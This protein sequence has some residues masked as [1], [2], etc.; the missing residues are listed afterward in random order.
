G[1]RRG[2]GALVRWSVFGVAWVIVKLWRGLTAVVGPVMRKA[3]DLAMKPYAGAE[4]GYLKLLPSA[5]AHPGKVLGL[6]ALAF[7]ATRAMV[8]MLGADLIPQL[9]QDRFEMTAKLPAGT[10]LKQTDALVRELQLAHAK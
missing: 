3:S 9:A 10:P 6:A 1:S 7:V 2:L 4:R 8:P 5:L